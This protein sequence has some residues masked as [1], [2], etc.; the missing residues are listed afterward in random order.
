MWP[1]L[2]SLIPGA[3][4]GIW[5]LGSQWLENR[6][7][8][9]EVKGD[10]EAKKVELSSQLEI[11]KLQATVAKTEQDGVW[12]NTQATNSNNSWK[13]EF[14][15]LILSLPMI[16]VTVSP[17]IDM[18]MDPEPYQKGALIQAAMTSL[19]AFDKFPDWY[20]LLISVAVGAAFG[21]RVWDR[22]R[23]SR[24]RLVITGGDNSGG[25][26]EPAPVRDA[27]EQKID[28]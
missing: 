13:D 16:L 28:K 14:W 6:R 8:I 11:A 17:L 22:F 26:P 15:T 12:E 21:V 7:K 1:M 19:A 18:F 20:V 2:A 5:N 24:G 27:I 23:A 3:L 25:R 4:K 10:L 9:S